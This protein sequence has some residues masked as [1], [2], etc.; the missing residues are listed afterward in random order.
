MRSVDRPAGEA[1]LKV[2]RWCGEFRCGAY[3]PP[4]TAGVPLAGWRR[5]LGRGSV[6]TVRYAR[7]KEHELRVKNFTERLA[8]ASA[9]RRWPV[10]GCWLLAVVVSAAA[11]AG[12]LGSALTTEDDFTGRPEAQRAE[13]LLKSA[14]PPPRT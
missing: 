4:G 10:V 3:R 9:R 7:E 8:R 1:A 6:S 2:A 11:I 14:F 5:Q 13:L 12:L